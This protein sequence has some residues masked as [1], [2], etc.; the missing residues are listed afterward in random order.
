MSVRAYL[1]VNEDIKVIDGKKYVHEEEEYL[2]SNW[3]ESGA[4]IWNILFDKMIDYTNEDCC[5]FIEI[6]EDAWE[7]LKE[8]YATRNSKYGKKV[9]K[10]V[11]E[12]KEVFMKMDSRFKSGV[13]YIKINLY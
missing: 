5:G 10:V 4:D 2:W 13:D 6:N 7:D 12:N 1:V 3:S 8:D 11:N 9:Y